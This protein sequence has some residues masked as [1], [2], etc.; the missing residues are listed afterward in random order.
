MNGRLTPLFTYPVEVLALCQQFR[1]EQGTISGSGKALLY[2]VPPPRIPELSVQE[3]YTQYAED[4]LKFAAKLD[5]RAKEVKRYYRNLE[6]LRF[7]RA[8]WDALLIGYQTARRESLKRYGT[9]YLNSMKLQGINRFRSQLISCPLEAAQRLKA[10][11][12]ANRAWFYGGPRPGGRLLVVENK[13][14]ALYVSYL[15]RGLPPAPPSPDGM[16][17]LISRLTAEPLPEHPG[18][19]DFVRRYIARFGPDKK[20]AALYTMPSGSGALGLTRRNGGHNTGVQHLVLLGYA[21]TKLRSMK[22]PGVYPFG[23]AQQDD[24]SYLELLSQSVVSLGKGPNVLFDTTWEDLERVMPDLT[25]FFQ[26]YLRVGVEYVMDNITYLPILPIEA[27]EKGLKTRYPTCCLTAANLVQ[28]VL[29]RVV[30][31]VMIRDPRCAVALGAEEGIDL[32]GEEGPWDSLDATVATDKHTQWLTQ[33]VYEELV[34]YDQRLKPYKKWFEKLFGPKKILIC[35]QDDVA[36]HGLLVN[37]PSAPFLTET[38]SLGSN[39]R[40]RAARTSGGHAGVILA[41]WKDYI[42]DLNSMTG[43]LTKTGQ[44]MGDPTSFPP[45]ML[46]SIFAGDLAL[47][48]IPYTK[49]EAKRRHPGL[50]KGEFVAELVGDDCAA[51]RMSRERRD[52]FHHHHGTLGSELSLKKC[53]YHK[54]Y[55]LIAEQPMEH[56]R[57]L[58]YYPLAELIAP[59]GGSKGSVSWNNQPRALL[60][61]AKIL[62]FAVKRGLLRKSPYWY[63]W[64]YAQK[65]G[66]PLAAPEGHGGI[67]LKVYPKVSMTHHVAW[68]RYL[69][70][71]PLDELVAGTS[72][73]IGRAPSSLMAKPTRDWIKKVIADDKDLKSIGGLLSPM[74]YADTGELRKDLKSAYREAL[75]SVRSAEFYFRAP[76]EVLLDRTPSVKVA[77]AKFQRKVSKSPWFDKPGGWSY[78]PTARDLEEKTAVFFTRGGSFLPDRSKPRTFFGLEQTDVVK[79]RYKA[80]HLTGVG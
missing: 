35:D 63:T 17:G 21:L 24:G 54:K 65:M 76:P 7:M 73:S 3:F 31:H 10:V 23:D 39:Q 6:T 61:N 60:G 8:T 64:A 18:W 70:T 36:P 38:S 59:P 25:T 52:R 71:L 16:P 57:K 22:E 66:L 45:L 9:W 37:Y 27:E 68:L 11:A 62:R 41:L 19:R 20:P 75:S 55:S 33:T 40:L 14:V 2:V 56:G 34:E 28:Q 32:R 26:R 15:A 77:A 58:P 4:I 78:Q 67:N 44:M 51:P 79:Q 1:Q 72:L 47:R 69:S 43:I 5:R 74:P 48:D 46:V 50:R 42:D 12:Q 29:R 13:R 30:D 49:E 80:P 53:F